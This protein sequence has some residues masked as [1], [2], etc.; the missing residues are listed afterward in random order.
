M[1]LDSPESVRLLLEAMKDEGYAV[2]HVPDDSQNLMEEVLAHATNDRKFLTAAAARLAEGHL[3]ADAYKE[4][5]AVLP[6]RQKNIS[7]KTGENRSAMYLC[8][9]TSS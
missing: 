4:F 3:E 8:M 7:S 1:G 5:S 6:K 9:I 2:D